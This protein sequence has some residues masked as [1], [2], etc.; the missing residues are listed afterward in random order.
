MM[1]VIVV[2]PTSNE[3][4]NVRGIVARALA[5]DPAYHVLVVDDSSP[6]GTAGIVSRLAADNPRVHLLLRRDDRGFG[7]AVRDGFV[8]ALQ[9]GAPLIGQM[10]PDGPHAPATFPAPFGP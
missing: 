2:I 3:A 10:D 9:L 4:D 6:D 1:K 5:V 7:T 8:Q